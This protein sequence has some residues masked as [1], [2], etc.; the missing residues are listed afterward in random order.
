MVG[1]SKTWTP[2]DREA[3]CLEKE[4]AVKEVV[5]KNP[6][7]SVVNEHRVFFHACSF[8]VLFRQ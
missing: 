1:H 4:S 3:E 2:E 5:K 8:S 6:G 7:V